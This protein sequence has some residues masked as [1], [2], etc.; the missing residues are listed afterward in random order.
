MSIGLFREEALERR[1]KLQEGQVIAIAPLSLRVIAF[2]IFS[3]FVFSLLIAYN[4]SF[5]RTE[6]VV[7]QI[8]P[9]SGVIA[10]TPLR[11]GYLADI[12]FE[13]GERVER[14][15]VIATLSADTELLDGTNSRDIKLGSLA[16][17]LDALE[18][19]AGLE[20]IRAQSDIAS[21]NAEKAGLNRERQ[22]LEEQYSL[23][24]KLTVSSQD[25]FKTLNSLLEQG[26]SSN[27]EVEQRKQTWLSNARQEQ[28][29]L[30]QIVDLD[31]RLAQ[32][33]FRLEAR[34]AELAATLEQLKSRRA[35]LARLKADEEGSQAFVITAP[36]SG[37]ITS[38]PILEG[39]L[40]EAGRP[41]AFIL[42]EGEALEA[43]L[44]V[45]SRAIGFVEI[46]QD[47]RLQYDAFPYE[48]FGTG[49][50]SIKRVGGSVLTAEDT[51]L[52]VRMDEP[53][54]ETRVT[55]SAP[56]IQAFGKDY[57][58]QPGMMLKA[59]IVLERQT[60]LEW[61]LE[62]LNAVRKRV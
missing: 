58:L 42:P 7:G 60:F 40:A 19:Q 5:A 21:L 57:T 14:G 34:Q 51:R 45:P 4:G 47:V 59:N 32:F 12:H 56:T 9:S 62:P 27:A 10:A 55:L 24:G 26:H 8:V 22:A 44:F 20:D 50:G 18:R 23:Q 41:I 13:I 38:F 36:I 39:G 54:Y 43:R 28:A 33:P 16:D 35:E 11:S 2:F 31:K 48:R 17:Q 37:Q 46:G 52:P 53:F 49:E 3:L 1:R 25:A 6:T 30:Q 29:L 15:D 61:L